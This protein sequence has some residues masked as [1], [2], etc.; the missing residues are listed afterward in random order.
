MIFHFNYIFLSKELSIE[1]LMEKIKPVFLANYEPKNE[2]LS[3]FKYYW[4]FWLFLTAK[5]QTQKEKT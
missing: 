4:S 3:F 5:M 1:P 2:D